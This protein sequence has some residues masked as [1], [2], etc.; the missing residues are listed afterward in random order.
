MQELSGLLRH[1]LLI[2]SVAWALTLPGTA[3]ADS[4]VS[5]VITTTTTT[6]VGYDGYTTT[7]M[8]SSGHRQ[9]FNSPYLYSSRVDNYYAGYGTSYEM[10][11]GYTLI[12]GS[13]GL[14]HQVDL[15]DNRT[16]VRMSKD[17]T[18]EPRLDVERG[19]DRGLADAPMSSFDP[20]RLEIPTGRTVTFYS[21]DGAHSIQAMD[22][23]SL[24]QT[25]IVNAD[26]VYSWTFTEPGLYRFEDSFG[27]GPSGSHIHGLV[28]HVYGDSVAWNDSAFC[29][30]DFMSSTVAYNA[31]DA[32]VV[33]VMERT[34]NTSIQVQGQHTQAPIRKVHKTIL[35]NKDIK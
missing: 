19:F 6:T 12:R 21:Q 9:D 8:Y 3:L 14:R 33:T 31:Q 4:A 22:G 29:D 11:R 10:A 35:R 30:A 20:Y 16:L 15:N 32:A 7:N 27:S 2:G 18:L 25:V 13:D 23:R 17:S 1:G 34:T 5:P 28:I 24:T 26:Q